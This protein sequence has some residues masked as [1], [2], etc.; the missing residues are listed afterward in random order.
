LLLLAS[1][2]RLILLGALLAGAFF[3][4]SLFGLG[5]RRGLL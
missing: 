5:L 2:L 1:L 3:R 4:R